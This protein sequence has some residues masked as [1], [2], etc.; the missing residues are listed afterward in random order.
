MEGLMELDGRGWVLVEGCCD[1]VFFG[2]IEGR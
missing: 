2:E 1:W